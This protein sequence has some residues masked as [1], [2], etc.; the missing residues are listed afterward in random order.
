[1][2]YI[3]TFADGSELRGD[4]LLVATGR[5]PRTADLGLETLGVAVGRGGVPV[6]ERMRV[7]DG[8]WAVGDV[9]GIMLFTHVG[10]YQG[11]IAA[12]DILGRPA[13]ADYR[14][15]PRVVF[16]DPQVAAVGATDGPRSGTGRMSEVPR[17]FTYE[18]PLERP[19]FLTVVADDDVLVGAYAVGPEA[20]EWLGQATVAIRAGVPLEVLRDVIQPF[21]TF[22]EIYQKALAVRLGPLGSCPTAVATM[23]SVA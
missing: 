6:D 22:S 9:T 7:A 10:K 12:A 17:A 4:R 23:A 3:L 5:A 13:R 11:R 2:D 19:G 8:V 1:D 14:A 20:G 21:P 18:R 15:V 16:T